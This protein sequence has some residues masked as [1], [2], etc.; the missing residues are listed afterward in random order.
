MRT[1]E[2]KYFGKS[3]IETRAGFKMFSLNL[4]FIGII[5]YKKK[6]SLMRLV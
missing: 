3:R 1:S 2:Y 6:I 4:L 5:Y